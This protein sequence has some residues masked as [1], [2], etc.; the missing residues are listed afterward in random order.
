LDSVNL[1]IGTGTFSGHVP[2]VVQEYPE[3]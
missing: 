2:G 1:W 3:R